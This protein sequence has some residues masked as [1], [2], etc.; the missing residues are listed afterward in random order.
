VARRCRD[1]IEHISEFRSRAVTRPTSG[2]GLCRW[3][4][5]AAASDATLKPREW[6]WTTLTWRARHVARAVLSSSVMLQQHYVVRDVVIVISVLGSFQ[7]LSTSAPRNRDADTNQSINPMSTWLNAT[8]FY[9]LHCHVYCVAC[10]VP[11]RDG[12]GCLLVGTA[13]AYRV[14]QKLARLF[15]PLNFTKH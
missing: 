14:A 15:V 5:R 9:S 2:S 4:C 7:S 10:D 3:R 11:G 6:S 8:L 13:G 1:V 12:G